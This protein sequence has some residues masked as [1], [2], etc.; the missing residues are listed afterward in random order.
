VKI[1]APATASD[2][3]RRI[4][5]YGTFATTKFDLPDSPARLNA[6][7]LIPYSYLLRTFKERPTELGGTDFEPVWASYQTVVAGAP[8]AANF[9]IVN[10]RGSDWLSPITECGVGAILLV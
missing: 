6:A 3:S 8:V 1:E 10:R 5:V 7:T 9:P 4:V 2:P